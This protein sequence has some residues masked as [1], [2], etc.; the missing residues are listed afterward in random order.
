MYKT[1]RERESKNIRAVLGMCRWTFFW[2]IQS[3]E[4]YDR[5]EWG[6][7]SWSYWVGKTDILLSII[8]LSDTLYSC[9]ESIYRFCL[10]PHESF[11]SECLVLEYFERGCES[12][13]CDARETAG[14]MLKYRLN[15]SGGPFI[16]RGAYG[17]SQFHLNFW[18]SRGIDNMQGI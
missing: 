6:L 4:Y 14:F 7:A 5:F 13:Q 10:G 9:A 11:Y 3:R 8:S 17:F 2:L 12:A 15:F 16:N 18:H 1:A